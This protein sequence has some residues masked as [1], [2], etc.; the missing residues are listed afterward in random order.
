MALFPSEN[1]SGKLSGALVKSDFH[2]PSEAGV[3]IYFNCNPDLSVALSRVEAAGGKTMMPKTLISAENGYM[4]FV[5][6]SEG[7]RVALHSNA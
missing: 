2:T 4:A 6:D 3:I 5:T 7:N 1:G